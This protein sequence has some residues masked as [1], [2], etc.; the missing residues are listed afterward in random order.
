MIQGLGSGRQDPVV[1]D[2]PRATYYD[3]ADASNGLT[4]LL[5]SNSDSPVAVKNTIA[6]K[7]IYSGWLPN[8]NHLE[9]DRNPVLEPFAD[10]TA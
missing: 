9:S 8:R 6:L 2:G 4:E 1:A 5:S 7:S 3:S 10:N